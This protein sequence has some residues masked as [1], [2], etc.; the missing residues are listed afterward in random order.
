MR[1][2]NFS[3]GVSTA[4]VAMA[5]VTGLSVPVDAAKVDKALSQS[6]VTKSG[7]SVMTA[8]PTVSVENIADGQVATSWKVTVSDVPANVQDTEVGVP[9]SQTR[10]LVFDKGDRTKPLNGSASVNKNGNM[11]YDGGRVFYYQ[12]PTSS[13]YSKNE[14]TISGGS[15]T[16]GHI[17]SMGL[18]MQL[19]I[20]QQ[21]QHIMQQLIHQQ[22]VFHGLIMHQYSLITG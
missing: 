13:S 7:V 19:I 16:P 9:S 8:A 12:D 4:L 6:E 10:V 1:K 5:L 14:F 2:Y 20:K 3:K 22:L 21:E 18:D 11:A 15:F 17:H